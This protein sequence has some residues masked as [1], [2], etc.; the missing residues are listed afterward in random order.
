M[1][2]SRI[3]WATASASGPSSGAPASSVACNCLKTCLG[4]RAR[5]SSTLNTLAPKTVAPG[6]LPAGAL[7]AAREDVGAEAVGA[8]RRQVGRAEGA[9]VDRP[10]RGRD[11]LL[12]GSHGA[13]TSS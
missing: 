6:A 3:A 5:C 13:G 11:V 8:R 4:R 10:L 1:A 9:A 7:L 12:A 2:H